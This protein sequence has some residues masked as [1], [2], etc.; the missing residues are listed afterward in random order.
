MDATEI[1]RAIID[2]E[3][4]AQ[5]LGDM[6]SDLD[7]LGSG[8]QGEIDK[9]ALQD[10]IENVITAIQAARHKLKGWPET[11]ACGF[12]SSLPPYA[13]EWGGQAVML[14]QATANGMARYFKAIDRPAEALTLLVEDYADRE[15][16]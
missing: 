11:Y 4:S 13:W 7:S 6:W 14:G 9:D 1:K 2:L 12:D 5:S 3:L 8:P 10:G 16:G 15:E